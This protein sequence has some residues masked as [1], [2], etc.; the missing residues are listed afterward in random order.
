[1]KN[2][3]NNKVGRSS[4]FTWIQ[5][6]TTAMAAL[7]I[8]S[9]SNRFLTQSQRGQTIVGALGCVYLSVANEFG[10]FPFSFFVKEKAS[11]QR[12]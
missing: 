4:V 12:T 6:G 2:E 1:M 3:D 10:L 5:Y 8:M 11:V 7:F 9:V